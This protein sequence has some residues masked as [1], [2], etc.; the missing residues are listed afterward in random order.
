MATFDLPLPE[1]TIKEFPRAWTRFEL[2]SVAKEWNAKIQA[3]TLPTLLR[4]KLVDYYA[5]SKVDL[6]L[7]KVVLMKKAGLTQDPLIVGKLL[8]SLCKCSGENAVDFADNLKK[9]FKQAYPAEGLASGI[10][11]QCFL[12]RLVPP[13]SQ[14]ILLR[15]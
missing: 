10:L 5:T 2:V 14:Q 4:G 15:G 9:L 13:I 11:L 8:I 3:L 1:I 6:N 7:L 12:A